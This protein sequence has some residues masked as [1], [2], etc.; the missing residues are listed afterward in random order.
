VKVGLC[1][2]T[3]G[4]VRPALLR[5]LAGCDLILHAGDVGGSDV[6]EAL[7]AVAPLLLVRGNNDPLRPDWPTHR[8][9]DLDGCLVHLV[10]DRQDARPDKA[11]VVVFGHSH[12][13][14]VEERDGQLWVN[15]GSA[16]PRRFR[17]PVEAA[18]LRLDRGAPSVSAVDLLK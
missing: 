3:H 18:I 7:A 2:D 1:A 14:S 5:A 16:G 10:H 8:D 4:L 6:A 17:L 12:R 9:L 11:R 15:P 13:P